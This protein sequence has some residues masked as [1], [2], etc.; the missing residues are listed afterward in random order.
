MHYKAI[1][2]DFIRW[3]N[4]YSKHFLLLLIRLD[5]SLIDLEEVWNFAYKS[6]YETYAIGFRFM[7]LGFVFKIAKTFRHWLAQC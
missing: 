1:F 3:R 4:K 5:R 7:T 2:Y 6:Q